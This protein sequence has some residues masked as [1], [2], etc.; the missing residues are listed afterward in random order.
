MISSYTKKHVGQ[1]KTYTILLL[2]FFA[3]FCVVVLVPFA[4]ILLT[5]FKQTN[6]LL[7]DGFNLKVEKNIM[8]WDSYV[9]LFTGKHSFFLWYRNSVYLT[10]V[11]TLLTLFI[12]AWVS[13]GFSFYRFKGK[14]I[15]YACVLIVMMI[16]FEIMMLPLFMEAINLKMTNSYFGIMIPYLANATVIFFFCQYLQGIPVELV[17]AG[18]IDGCNEYSIFLCLV[19]P[20]MKPALAAMSILVGVN[21]WN[22]YLWPLLVLGDSHKFTLPIGLSSLIAMQGSNLNSYKILMAGSVM[23]VLPILLLFCFAQKYFIEGLSTGSVKG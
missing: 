21:T 7:T 18:R 23:T 16:P 11:Q 8:S 19:F 12:S 6:R 9:Y 20:L 15:L 3:M 13:F 1:K 14:D 5:S 4:T 10:V 17:E 2:V 22:N